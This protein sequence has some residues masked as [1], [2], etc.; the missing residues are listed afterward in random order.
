VWRNSE[1]AA[2]LASDDADLP[3][4]IPLSGRN[5]PFLHVIVADE[6]FPLNTSYVLM[7]DA[8]D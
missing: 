2:D 8:M 5:V 7:Q 4:L 1:L 3:P 6:V